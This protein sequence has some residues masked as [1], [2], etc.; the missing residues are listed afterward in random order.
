M[1]EILVNLFIVLIFV[2]LNPIYA[3]FF[4]AL[5]NLT[6]F[7]INYWIF[8]FMFALSFSLLFY[9]KDYSNVTSLSDLSWY[10]NSFK[11]IDEQSWSGIVT[12]FIDKPHANEPLFWI[13]AKLIMTIFPSNGGYFVFFHYFITFVLVAYL[14]KI[15]HANK[16]VIIILCVLLTNFGI[17][18]T[19]YQLWRHTFAYLL[20]MIGLF[21]FDL[22]GKNLRARIIIYCSGLIHLSLIPIILF[23]EI[24]VLFYKNIH[25]SKIKKLFSKEIIGYTVSV[26]LIFILLSKYGLIIGKSLGVYKDLSIYFQQAIPAKLGYDYLFN[27]FSFVVCGFLWLRRKNLTKADIFIASQYFIIIIVL[28][29]LEVPDIFS[30]Y[31]YYIMLGGSILIG[32]LLISELRIG[33]IFII[34]LFIFNF[35]TL[36]YSAEKVEALS[37]RLHT[38]FNN[39]TY[40]LGKMVLNYDTIL[41]YNF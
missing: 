6:S 39:P 5:I 17:L 26:V 21:S 34:S 29:E 25:N 22:R 18:T 32:K 35:Y 20:F 14:G 12:R 38:E 30:R 31:S 40:G 3:L 13:Y 8:T 37:H 28:I 23:F 15:I 19:L 9:L 33:L 1:K 10:I 11:S 27:S 7:R 16:Y 24:F 2:F 36:N 4:C 41:N